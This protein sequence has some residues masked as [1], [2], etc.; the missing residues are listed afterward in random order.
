VSVDAPELWSVPPFRATLREGRI[1][2]RGANDMKG[3]ITALLTALEALAQAGVELAGDVVFCTVTDE[4]SS[5]AGGWAAVRHGVRASAGVCAEPTDLN[6]CI[7]C[8]GMVTPTITIHG[9]QGHAEIVQ[10]HWR[11][12]GAVN[13]IEKAQLI[14]D[15]ARR[16]R[17][18]WRTRPDYQHP[19]LHPGDIVP[20]VMSAGGWHVT[21]PAS[22]TIKFDCQYL[23]GQVDE[24]GTGRA[25]EREIIEWM[26]RAA[27]A[28]EWLCEHPLEWAWG[29]DVV[30]A[31]MPGDS[32][33]VA[34]TQQCAA[35]TG[36]DSQVVG[37][38]SWYDAATFTAHGTPTLSFGPRDFGTIHGVDE[39]VSVDDLV[40]VASIVA[41]AAMRYCGVS[42]ED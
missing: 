21:Y 23:P 22:C 1:Y 34:V 28:D 42:S 37:F 6:L 3:G 11:E 40:E 9:R 29:S 7:A 41:L 25:V 14:L 16:L 38:D 24:Q 36:R 31:E 15:A 8:R 13:A 30:P 32:P 35:D 33:L 5:G 19:L 20:T 18:E 27:A 39:C 17:E 26:E 12:G 2:G 4:E 10:P